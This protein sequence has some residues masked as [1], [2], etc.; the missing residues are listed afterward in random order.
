MIEMFVICSFVT[1]FEFVLILGKFFFA[2][3]F[4]LLIVNT[5]KYLKNSKC[6]LRLSQIKLAWDNDFA[7]HSFEDTVITSF[8]IPLF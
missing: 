2:F 6:S 7:Q 8:A 3:I 1:F 5:Q 4:F